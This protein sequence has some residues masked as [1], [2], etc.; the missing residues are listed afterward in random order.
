MHEQRNENWTILTGKGSVILNDELYEVRAGS[1]IEIPAGTKHA[2]KARTD[3]EL[4]EVQ[5]GSMLSE[6]DI[7]RISMD[8]EEILPLHSSVT[9]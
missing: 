7:Y 1:I 2:L 4:I 6:E 9:L 8:W 5:Q 3:M